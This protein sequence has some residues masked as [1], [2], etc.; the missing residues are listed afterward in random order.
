MMRD[1]LEKSTVTRQL[2]EHLQVGPLIGIGEVAQLQH[3]VDVARAG[4]LAYI[5]A[6]EDNRRDRCPATTPLAGSPERQRGAERT[7]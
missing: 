6:V 1:S 5:T 7:S 2:G 4:L 3:Q